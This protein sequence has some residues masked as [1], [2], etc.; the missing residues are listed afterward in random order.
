MP[1]DDA[2]PAAAPAAPAKTPP[3]AAAPAAP[4]WSPKVGTFVNLTETDPRT[5]KVSTHLL[6][7][8]GSNVSRGPQRDE[9]GNVVTQ[10]VPMKVGPNQEVRN[11]TQAVLV[12]VTTYEGVT[13]SAQVQFPV[14]KR[15]VSIAAL[16]PL[17]D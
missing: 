10:V 9:K 2:T 12:D 7:V 5:K 11:I 13:F 6:L 1:T 15:G 17:E 16:S 3:P 14:P 4:A 8:T